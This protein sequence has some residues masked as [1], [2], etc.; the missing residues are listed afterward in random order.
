MKQWICKYCG[1]DTKCTDMDYLDGYDHISCILKMID[2]AKKPKVMKIKGWEKIS[3]YTYKGYCIVNPIHNA[4]E[5]KYMADVINLNLPQKPKWELN[6]LTPEHKFKAVDDDTFHI[7]LW[8]ENKFS[9]RKNVS[10]DMISNISGFR[11]LCEELIDEMLKIQLTSAPIYSSQSVGGIVNHVNNS[12]TTIP[13]GQM[14]Q[15]IQSMQQTI[16]NLTQNTPS[17]P[18]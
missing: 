1:G 15:S 2:E 18:F 5:T 4:G 14:V 16:N 10:K 3:G 6:V 12:G 9:T 13:Y 8:D 17:N 7:L 11:V